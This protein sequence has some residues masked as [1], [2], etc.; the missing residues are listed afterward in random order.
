MN[1][2]MLPTADF[3]AETVILANG[4][5]PQGEIGLS[6]LKNAR[7]LV[8]CDGAVNQLLE[9]GCPRLPDAVVGDC[10][11]VSA[12]NLE[13]FAGIVRRV[14]EQE[15]NDL[16]KAVN[17]CRSEGRVS[18]IILGATGRREDHTLA[19]ISLLAEYLNIEES[20]FRMVTDHGVFT[21]V[22]RGGEFES[23][24]GQQVSIFN[25]GG[26]AVTSSGLKY[27]LAGHMLK[28]LWEGTLNESLDGS[29]TL[30]AES[31]LLVFQEF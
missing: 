3:Q 13:R 28:N 14:P 10:D 8:C 25:L 24:A 23:R 5:F 31:A 15:T 9:N 22:R 17:F 2:I 27:P 1:K 21:A 12:E 29:F 6:L 7:Y 16:T 19:N 20:D 4:G 26:G 18:A 30:Q 11:S